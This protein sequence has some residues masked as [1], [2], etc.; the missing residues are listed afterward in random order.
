MLTFENRG[1]IIDVRF[2]D[3]DDNELVFDQTA[4]AII[5]FDFV[6]SSTFHQ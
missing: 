5:Q 3:M 1:N 6:E 2:T 4:P